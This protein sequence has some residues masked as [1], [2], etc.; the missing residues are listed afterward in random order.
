MSNPI[1][2]AGTFITIEEKY[3]AYGQHLMHDICTSTMQ[4]DRDHLS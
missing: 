1:E 3:T 4:L 2:M